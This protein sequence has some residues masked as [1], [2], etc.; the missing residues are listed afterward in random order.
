MKVAWVAGFLVGVMPLA[1]QDPPKAIPLVDPEALKP[2][3][4]EAPLRIEEPQVNPGVPKRERVESASGQ[5]GVSGGT[6]EL[7]SSL[8]L[9]AEA[10]RRRFHELLGLG[11][12]PVSI[13]VEI[14]L[15]GQPGD[16]A[17]TRAIEMELRFTKETHFLNIHVDLS[18][19]VDHEPLRKAILQALISGRSLKDVP[20]GSLEAP[21]RVPVWLL[22]G[23]LEADRWRRGAGDRRLYDG[24]FKSEGRFSIDEVLGMGPTEHSRLDGVSREMF[25]VL[26]GALVMALLEQPKGRASLASFCTEVATFQGEMPI[27]LRRHFPGLNLSEN[28]L[29]KWWALT[30]AKLSDAPLTDSMTIAET[31]R[32]L[33]EALALRFEEDGLARR[34]RLEERGQAPE[35]DERARLAAIRPA[36]QALNRLSYRCFPSYRP[37]LLDYQEWLIDWATGK[38]GEEDLD[39]MLRDL[40][41]TR[42]IMEGRAL[43][44]RDYL[45]Y[46][47]IAGASELSGSFEDYLRLKRDLEERPRVEKK[48]PVSAYL[49]RMEAVYEPR[50]AR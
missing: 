22:E 17:R 8:A 37:L 24:V 33:E 50:N 47:E 38:E 10:E 15:H 4:G 11:K 21:V 42:A 41:E 48:D 31:E 49:D 2:D 23:L 45:D 28:S 13:P 27:L 43:R 36:Q 3:E 25:R 32:Q 6:V 9:Q 18:R 26:S 7:R 1:A 14:L 35:F 5:F 44:A 40:A 46:M 20:P 34:L 39:A 30:L 29:M 12:E 16:A 19:G